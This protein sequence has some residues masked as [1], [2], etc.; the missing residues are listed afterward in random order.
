MRL[1]AER[2][3]LVTFRP[4]MTHSTHEDT[5]L[6]VFHFQMLQD[7]ITIDYLSR[8]MLDELNRWFSA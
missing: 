5:P 7:S 6:C 4:A 3:R 2:E 1:Q 8:K